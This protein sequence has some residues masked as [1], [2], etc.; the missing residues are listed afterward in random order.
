M[1][2]YEQSDWP[3]FKWNAEAFAYK[4]ADIRYRQGLLLGKMAGIG[5]DLKQEASLKTLTSDIVTSSAIE[6]ELLNREEVRSSIARRLGI[7][8]AGLVPA[9]R[10]IDGFVEMMIDATHNFSR[11]LTE[12]RLFAWHSALFPTGRSGMYKIAVGKW[13]TPESGVMQVVSG[14]VGRE[15]IHFEAPHADKISDEM[16][17]FLN[18]FN[19]DTTL[20]PVIKAGVA[21]LLFVTIHPFEDG[22]GRIA[23]AITD[24]LLVRADGISER[25]YSLS[26]QIE[27]ERKDY[28]F[29]L[30]RQQKGA[31]DV[32][33]WLEWFLDC[34]GRALERAEDTLKSIIYKTEL[35]N[36]FKQ[37]SINERQ[38]MI[39]NLMLDDSFEGYMNTSKYAKLAKCSNDTA[40][41]DI[42]ELKAYGV[43]IQNI[44]GGRSTSYRLREPV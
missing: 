13:R 4:L 8:I 34:L 40:L 33:G 31:T 24:M 39:I 2:I 28:Y 25:F 10:N 22:N 9:S 23:R 19:S 15:K 17:A 41:R 42:Q 6:G 14:P 27:A 35:W 11:D 30:E 16:V 37:F 20:D 32:T 5:F 38:R 44:A 21:H 29:Q 26:S 1:W 43:F 36:H 7:D 18:W 12:E 3:H